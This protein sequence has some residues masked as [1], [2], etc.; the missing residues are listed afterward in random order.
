MN[1][2]RA[3]TALPAIVI[4][5]AAGCARQRTAGPS[6]GGPEF[7]RPAPSFNPAGLYVWTNTRKDIDGAS[8]RHRTR[9]VL[10]LTRGHARGTGDFF[11][12]SERIG[13]PMRPDGPLEYADVHVFV[14]GKYRLA[15][16]TLTFHCKSG[17]VKTGQRTER[18][19]RTDLSRATPV[20]L[21]KQ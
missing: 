8:A 6:M 4:L 13:V 14:A 7:A 12:T 17:E 2:R 18:G 21:L 9:E 20:E 15:G 11:L 19:I 10:I 16:D 3:I 1:A 5:L